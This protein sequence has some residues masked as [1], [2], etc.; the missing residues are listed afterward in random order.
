M[1]HKLVSKSG[2]ME[3]FVV[4]E[5]MLDEGHRCGACH[6]VSDAKV[7]IMTKQSKESEYV[8]KVSVYVRTF[9]W[10]Y[11]SFIPAALGAS[12]WGC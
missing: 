4:C 10:L 2:Q 11:E 12:R 6:N 5:G 7:R 8:L 1:K 3:S 9:Y